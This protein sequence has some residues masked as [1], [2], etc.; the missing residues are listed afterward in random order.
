MITDLNKDELMIDSG[1]VTHVC[2][3]WFASTTQTYDLPDHERPNLRTAT[4]DPIEVYGYKWV[5]MT[6]ESNQQI[7]I[8]FYVCSVSQP[9]LSVTRLAEQGFTIH[10]SEHP[11]ITHPNGFEAKLRT[12]E[13]TYFLPVNN[14]GTPPNYKLD[15]H[16]TQQGIKATISPITL[17]PGGAQWVTHQHDIWTY[18]SQGYLVRLH[19]AKR[20]ATYMPDQQCPVPMDKLED[21]RRTIAHKHDGTTEDFEE[22]LHSLEHTQQK[23]MLNT[24]WKGET[25]FK[26]KQNARPPKPPITTPATTGKA[27]PAHNQQQQESLQQKRRYTEKKPERPEEMATSSE[28]Q[29]S[30]SQQSH[31]ATSIPRPKEVSA[32][33]DYW[34]REGHLWKRVHR[35]PR[36]ELYIPQQTQDGPDVTK[37]NPERTTMVRPTSGARW[38][39]IDDD[40]T[41]KRQATLNVPWTGSTNFEESTSYK[42]EVHDVDEEDPQHAKP[43]RGLTA[44]AQPT[45][46]E[47]AEHELTHLPFR[48]WCPTCVANKGRADNHPKQKSKMPVV[49]F[50][51]CYFKTAGEPTASAILT[52]I[53]VETG[54]VMA[55]MVGDKQQDFQY[56]VN[57]IQSFLMECGRVQAILNSTIL[58]SDQEDH[59]IALLQTVASKMGGNITVRQSPTY[60]SQAQGSVERFHRTLMGQIRTLRAQLQQNYD[61]TITSKHPI[62]PWLVR[63]TAYLLNRYAT[64]ADG[65][66]SYFRRWNKDHRAPICE[67]GETVQYLL[68]TVKQ[69]PKMEQRFFKAIWLG[70]DTATG[71]TLLGISNKVI[72]ARTIRRMPK[73]EKYDKQMFDIISQTGQTMTPPPTS[74]AQLQPP[75]VFHPPRRQTT[76]TESQTSTEQALML[77]TQAGGPQLPPKAI[78]D[79]PLAT[80]TPALANSPM[81]TAPTSCHS[82]PAMPSPPKRQVADDIAEGSATKQQRTSTQQEAPARPEPTPEQPKSRLRITKVT[83]QTKQGE[84]ITAYSCEDATEQQTE[85]ILLEPI[86]S[87]TD[88]LDK[89]KTTEG[90]KQEILSMKQQQVYMEVDINTLTPEQRKNIIQS[91][92]VLRDKGN[93]VR[94]RIVAKGFTETIHDLDDIYASTPIFCV[95]RTLL[96][97]ASN[98]GWIGITGDISTAF[99]HAAA[100]TADLYM[101]PPKEF[102]NPED[103][104]VWKLLKAIYGLRSSPKAWQKHLSEVLQQIGLHRSTAEP[105]IYMTTTRNCFVLVYVDDLLFLGEEQTVNKLF[106][107]IQQQLLLRPTGTL[108]TGNTVAFLGRNITNRGDYYEISLADEY[109]TTLLKETN[110][111][112]SKPAP[113]PGTSALKTATAD[114]DQ[115]LSTEEHAQY[116]R[117]V[118]KL[119]WMTYTR[120]DISYATKELARALQQPTTA[121][122]QK[123]KHLLRY[124]K[125]TKD[126]KQIIRPTVK[127][128]AKAIPDINVYVDSDWAGCPTTRKSTTGFII[129]LL[130]TTIN[131]GSRTQATIA[132]SSAEAELY[133]INTGATE[134]L[135]IRSLLMELLNINKIN[136][137][138]HTDSSSGKSMATRIGSSRKAKHIE[139]KHLFI[140]QLI[141]HDYVRIIK[142]HTNDNSADI[143]TKYVSTETLQ[144]HLQQAGIGIQHLN[145]H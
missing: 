17:T 99:L 27:L 31:S 68:P 8:P 122:Q 109:V 114:H 59:L 116:R 87:N 11:T 131:Y 30:R 126:Y 101:Y 65:N 51:F 88:G 61:R 77:P 62:V 56:H 42:D 107:A 23:R 63:H 66:T 48:S 106:K 125:G 18:N 128:P 142:I 43:A 124:I 44:P 92:W 104:I 9:I 26:V 72:R 71:E 96:T 57:C 79:T 35:K 50:D 49:Q 69:L 83:I 28:Q 60:T 41:T 95:L 16:E 139:L 4:E 137:K 24:A 91:R 34:I 129:S 81:A 132:L 121:D 86:V 45:Q 21:Y 113:A 40:W 145:I 138:I 55:T 93:K 135:H 117:A 94:A 76:T 143:L 80:T 84:E 47:I 141:S 112:D 90:M 108:S 75:M 82:R 78:A 33:E 105:N 67:F 134:A 103:N 54:M 89:M 32:T 73:P 15:V 133:A 98:N 37:L 19:K 7:V 58:Q 64:H 111:Q 13:G 127:L 119:Q 3:I 130:G 14:T 115:P 70:R 46:Q 10:L 97:L 12:K 74:Q 53:D 123:L 85:R 20:R 144:R 5:Y 110:L 1:A 29:P 2:P 136:I 22:K 100:A 118:G 140:Q 6:N 120:P 39:R 25:W 52:G 38:Y 102:Y 36:T